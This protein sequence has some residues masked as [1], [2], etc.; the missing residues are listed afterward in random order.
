MSEFY[1]P[2]ML[3]QAQTNARMLR[4]RTDIA[5]GVAQGI[6]RDGK[7]LIQAT[8]LKKHDLDMRQKYLAISHDNL[9]PI[10]QTIIDTDEGFKIRDTM[11]T[12]KTG[13]SFVQRRYHVTS[14]SDTTQRIARNLVNH[15][16]D[17]LTR[18]TEPEGEPGRTFRRIVASA[19][20]ATDSRRRGAGHDIAQMRFVAIHGAAAR[21]PQRRKALV[22]KTYDHAFRAMVLPGVA[23]AVF[24]TIDNDATAFDTQPLAI[25][26]GANAKAKS[27][28][29]VTEYI[30]ELFDPMAVGV[31]RIWLDAP[32]TEQ[33]ELCVMNA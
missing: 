1:L 14:T 8:W 26:L 29:A 6:S 12:T 4:K 2:K 23:M 17:E 5:N 15:S 27:L 9:G 11:L 22:E 28:E 16:L 21:D 3:R 7:S 30:M 19:D 10:V 18:Y 32:L 33:P 20:L 25:P 24:G 31:K 13:G